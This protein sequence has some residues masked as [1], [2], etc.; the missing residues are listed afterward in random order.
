[1]I[2]IVDSAECNVVI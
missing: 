1:M 2:D